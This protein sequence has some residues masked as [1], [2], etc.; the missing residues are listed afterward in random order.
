MVEQEPPQTILVP[1]KERPRLSIEN[2]V[3]QINTL[4]EVRKKKA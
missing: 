1:E 3:L 2:S 4:E